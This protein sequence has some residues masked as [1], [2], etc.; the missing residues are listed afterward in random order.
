[1]TYQTD[2]EGKDK[3][4]E[5]LQ[6]TL[7]DVLERQ[8][9]NSDDL[10]ISLQPLVIDPVFTPLDV[11]LYPC[12]LQPFL[13]PRLVLSYIIKHFIRPSFASTHQESKF[14]RP[15]S[16]RPTANGTM[17]WHDDAGTGL[18]KEQRSNGERSGRAWVD[19]IRLDEKMTNLLRP[20]PFVTRMRSS[21]PN[22]RCL[23][24]LPCR[25]SPRSTAKKGSSKLTR[26]T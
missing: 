1:M 6:S 5:A 19:T 11:L 7:K 25:G 21:R 12:L 22:L 4:F 14:A 10:K 16:A 3:E 15:G 20:R 9:D 2:L 24:E 8:G 17:A 26:N 18:G 23:K 13:P